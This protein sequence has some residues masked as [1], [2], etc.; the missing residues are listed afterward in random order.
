MR[1]S[2]DRMPMSRGLAGQEM[3]NLIANT[4]ADDNAVLSGITEC[5]LEIRDC[6]HDNLNVFVL[7]AFIILSPGSRACYV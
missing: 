5:V 2:R 3:R 4:K 7:I 6:V 1:Y